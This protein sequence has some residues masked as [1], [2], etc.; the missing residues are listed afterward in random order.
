MLTACPHCRVSFKVPDEFKGKK[1]KCPKC[2]QVFL[3]ELVASLAQPQTAQPPTAKATPAVP[4]KGIARTDTHAIDSSGSAIAPSVSKSANAPKATSA[5]RGK[6]D[7][8]QGLSSQARGERIM[9]GFRHEFKPPK[10]SFAYRMGLTAAMAVMMLL[11]LLYLTFIVGVGWLVYWH[12]T[13]SHVMVRNA[14]GRAAGIAL[15]IYIAPVIAGLISI[16]F[17][18]KPVFAR[19]AKQQRTRSLNDQGEPILFAFVQRICKE[20]GAPIPKRIDIDNEVNASASFRSGWW[21]LLRGNDLVLTLGM[22]LVHGL[23]L[24]QL[25]GVIAH[26]FGHFSQGAGMRV[27][28]ILR[29]INLW[30][31][32]AV[33]ERDNWDAWLEEMSIESD[34]RFG[35][36]FYVARFAVWISRRFLWCLLF[37]GNLLTGLIQQQMEYDADRYEV[38]MA[39]KNTFESTFQSLRTSAMGYQQAV[40][41]LGRVANEGRLVSDFPRLAALH[42]KKLSPELLQSMQAEIDKEKTQWFASHPSDSDRINAAKLSPD[43]GTYSSLLPASALFLHFQAECEGVTK[44]WY[45]AA[46]GK[47]FS[48]K[49]MV[50]TSEVMDEEAKE[51]IAWESLERFFIKSIGP[52]R[53]FPLPRYEIFAPQDP[54]H[55]AKLLIKARQTMLVSLAHYQS[56]NLIEENAELK[57]TNRMHVTQLKRKLS[58]LN[59]AG[60]R[61]ESTEQPKIPNPDRATSDQFVRASVIRLHTGCCLLMESAIQF[62]IL[63][64][65]MMLVRIQR[66]L[67]VLEAL[68]NQLLNIKA[69]ERIFAYQDFCCSQ[70][71]SQ[72]GDQSILVREVMATSQQLVDLYGE[73][74]RAFLHLAYPFDHAKKEMTVGQ[75]L[76]TDI[77]M[78][79]EVGAVMSA[80]GSL[81]NEYYNLRGRCLGHLTMAA[82]AVEMSLGMQPLK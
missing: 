82:E 53:E 34:F 77:L 12:L 14:R 21:S 10:T 19:P 58:K 65:A 51:D 76:T 2:K 49:K 7:E 36:I 17:M 64:G 30:F 60:L 23:T 70:F 46:L 68:D 61:A 48:E 63:D 59:E 44:D 4:S 22:P 79:E 20:L 28:F 75:H 5:Q 8:W 69:F 31:V 37:L 81:L 41:T 18:F 16:I 80:S 39:G 71:E 74:R 33:Y 9:S 1:G 6:K 35:W 50:P 27:S 67:P 3:V 24:Q 15:I 78:H 42:T 52:K 43:E 26:E 54:D 38:G 13:H 11:P 47:G 56:L 32:R 29:S 62:K 73:I 55:A 57:E 66:V 72:K 45:Q 40:G 25:A